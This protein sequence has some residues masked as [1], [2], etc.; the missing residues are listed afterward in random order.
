VYNYVA[1]SSSSLEGGQAVLSVYQSS[2]GQLSLTAVR[3]HQ[4]WYV[5]LSL[6]CTDRQR[7]THWSRALLKVTIF[8]VVQ[9]IMP[10]IRWVD[11]CK[12]T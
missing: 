4:S 7:K 5:S 6:S 9:I 1:T 3:L 8:H 11:T 2:C 10:S 12:H